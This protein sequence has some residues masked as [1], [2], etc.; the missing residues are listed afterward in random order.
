MD[1]NKLKDTAGG[2]AKNVA[3]KA[4]DA[5]EGLAEKASDLAPDAVKD[6]A[7]NV[8]AKAAKVAGDA[9]DKAAHFILVARTSEDDRRGHTAF[10][11][12]RDDPGWRID[13][14]IPIMGPESVD[15]AS[16]PASVR[17]KSKSPLSDR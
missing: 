13:R 7:K 16:T 2:L 5:A 17:Q 10:L 3:D 12:H 4:G 1:F 9:A 14:R 6:Q 15:A 8:A 11:F